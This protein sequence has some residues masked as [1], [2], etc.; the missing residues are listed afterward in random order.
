MM[1]V[2]DY[3]HNLRNEASSM[4]KCANK[5]NEK[6]SNAKKASATIVRPP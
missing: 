6:C 3:S 1:S 2:E 4:T 5:S